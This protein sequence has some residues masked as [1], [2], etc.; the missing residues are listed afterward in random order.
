MLFKSGVELN[1]NVHK[2]SKILLKF[3]SKLN[4]QVG[5][6]TANIAE[7]DLEFKQTVVV[8][9]NNQVLNLIQ[10]KFI[11]FLCFSAYTTSSVHCRV[12]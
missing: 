5:W 8:K 2:M 6:F 4:S 3:K 7:S 1:S 12:R 11:E 10:E 9:E